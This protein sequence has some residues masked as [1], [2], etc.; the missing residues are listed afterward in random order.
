[1]RVIRVIR[2]E[3]REK[4]FVFKFVQFHNLGKIQ[5]EIE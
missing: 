1:M 4:F 5:T 3:K 2:F